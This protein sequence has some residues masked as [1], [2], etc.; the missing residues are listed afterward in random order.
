MKPSPPMPPPERLAADLQ[1][2]RDYPSTRSIW[3][4]VGAST[5]EAPAARASLAAELRTWADRFAGAADALSAPGRD[6][7]ESSRN[8]P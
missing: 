5:P 8:D 1:R 7:G 2:M 3:H 6:P 4:R